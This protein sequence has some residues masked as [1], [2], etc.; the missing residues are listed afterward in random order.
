MT[1]KA[2][3]PI[4]AEVATKEQFGRASDRFEERCRKNN[5]TLPKDA[6][7]LVLEEE[8]D[9]LAQEM[10]E[11]LRKRVER[12]TTMIVRHATV[13]RNQTPKQILDATGRKQYVNKDILET[14]PGK[15]EG[16]EEIDVYFF[17]LGRWVGA[18]ELEREYALRGLTPDPYAQAQVNTDD[19]EFATEHPNST[20]WNRD[21]KVSSYLDFGRWG[22]GR[23]VYCGRYDSDWN[24][25]YWFSGVRNVSK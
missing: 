24:D 20:Q 7:Q 3:A 9:E 13:N 12:R 6:T 22:G 8:G 18:E 11:A 1:I 2:I 10:Y 19:P 15:G 5:A 23:E 21:G 16:A 14:M 4:A 17:K 25:D